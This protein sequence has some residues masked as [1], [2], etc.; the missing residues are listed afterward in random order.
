MSRQEGNRSKALRVLFDA[1]GEAG[2]VIQAVY[3]GMGVAGVGQ[4]KERDRIRDT[5]PWLVKCGYLVKKGRGPSAVFKVSGQ[6]M[7]RKVDTE[8]RRLAR[9]RA[10]A[11]ATAKAFAARTARVA[12]QA[13]NT[14]KPSKT[15]VPAEGETVE[16]FLA[17]GGQVQVLP[18]VWDREAA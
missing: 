11:D 14:P 3:E 2:L 8:Q 6:G 10:K 16:Q 17:R 13:A 18:S 4:A 15:P 5:V 12:M 1:A 7:P 9:E